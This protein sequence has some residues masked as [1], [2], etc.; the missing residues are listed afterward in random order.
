MELPV[1][2]YMAGYAGKNICHACAHLHERRE[3]N[4][5]KTLIWIAGCFCGC[6]ASNQ[7]YYGI[8]VVPLDTF[9]TRREPLPATVK[10]VEPR[11]SGWADWFMG[12]LP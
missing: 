8:G 6:T 10:P 2:N 3:T 12:L 7:E 1:G 11:R 9:E 5:D 4:S